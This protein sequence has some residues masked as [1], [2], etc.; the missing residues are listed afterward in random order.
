MA[1]STHIAK[2]WIKLS[3]EIDKVALNPPFLF[4]AVC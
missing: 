2:V 1:S 4:K 3:D